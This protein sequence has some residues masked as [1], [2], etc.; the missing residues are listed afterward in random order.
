MLLELQAEGP[1][2]VLEAG[3]CRPC[4]SP[5]RDRAYPWGAR[6]LLA[7]PGK[8]SPAGP[9]RHCPGNLRAAAVGQKGQGPVRCSSPLQQKSCKEVLKRVYLAAPFVTHVPN[10]IHGDWMWPQIHAIA[11]E[12]YRFVH[13][14][15]RTD[16]C[17]QVS[18]LSITRH[19][20][21]SGVN[22]LGTNTSPSSTATKTSCVP[23]Q[24]FSSHYLQT[25]VAL[26]RHKY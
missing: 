11:W 9:A 7:A 2:P 3:V 6:P 15:F 24:H 12:L 18:Q 23:F 13:I 19:H 10:P 16:T 1:I 21:R 5:A 26:G 8:S 4:S 14:G 22:L 25:V 20:H 17:T